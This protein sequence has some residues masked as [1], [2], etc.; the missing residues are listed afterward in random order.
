MNGTAGNTT[1]AKIQLLRADEMGAEHKWRGRVG[2]MSGSL[3]L[4]Y[5]HDISRELQLHWSICVRRIR[6]V[7][8][9]PATSLIH[10]ISTLSAAVAFFAR[11]PCNVVC[12]ACDLELR[13]Q[14]RK[15]RKKVAQKND[16]QSYNSIYGM[17]ILFVFLR[18]SEQQYITIEIV[19]K[20]VMLCL[21]NYQFVSA[22]QY[23]C[24]DCVE[25]CYGVC[26][27]SLCEC[28]G[29]WA[30][31][32]DAVYMCSQLLMETTECSRTE[33]ENWTNY[34]YAV[35]LLVSIYVGFGTLIIMWFASFSFNLF[36]QPIQS[37]NGNW[38]GSSHNAVQSSTGR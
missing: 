1:A 36:H 3:C 32:M 16:N 31:S 19:V 30:I 18:A 15:A 17:R 2:I 9:F 10:D 38:V 28:E 34:N 37:D 23:Y 25:T 33:T 29:G 24:A 26:G 5:L 11:Q 12:I 6:S 14:R 7:K 27:A 20:S 22:V 21:Q 8:S 35:S 13:R 4:C